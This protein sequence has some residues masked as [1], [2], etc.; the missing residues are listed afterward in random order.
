MSHLANKLKNNIRKYLKRKIRVNTKVKSHK[1]EHRL[2]INKSN[3]Y[4][5]AQLIDINGNVLASTTDK[6]AKGTTKIERA[7][8][9]GEEF[10][11]LI[12]SK[13]IEKIAFDRN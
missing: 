2:I 11:K 5:S 1:P 4:I 3:L 12:I 7:F 8:A 9:A 10:G 13:K 6:N